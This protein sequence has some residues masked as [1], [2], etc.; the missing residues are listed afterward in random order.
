MQNYIMKKKLI[1]QITFNDN[2][3]WNYTRHF[4]QSSSTISNIE[5]DGKQMFDDI[6]KS[7]IL[8]YLFHIYSYK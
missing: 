7:N 2:R 3:L 1:D 8:N 4:T 5:S 6:H